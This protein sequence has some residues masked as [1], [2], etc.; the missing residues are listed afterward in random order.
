MRQAGNHDEKRNTDDKLRTIGGEVKEPSVYHGRP[1]EEERLRNKVLHAEK[2]S[3]SGVVVGGLDAAADKEGPLSRTDASHGAAPAGRGGATREAPAP[4]RDTGNWFDRITNDRLSQ[5]G[6]PE[7]RVMPPGADRGHADE[8]SAVIHS[9]RRGQVHSSCLLLLPGS[10]DGNGAALQPSPPWLLP[11]PFPT[12]ES[13]FKPACLSASPPLR[14]RASTSSLQSTHADG[15]ERRNEAPI[16]IDEWRW[17][18]RPFW[19]SSSSVYF[20]QP[21]NRDT[22]TWPREVALRCNEAARRLPAF[23]VSCGESISTRS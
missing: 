14:L 17:W 8:A 16:S 10:E 3:G 5:W 2:H 7:P 1:F 20:S 12:E 19:F 9:W 4:S 6:Q 23:F 22:V 18:W 13:L 11:A 15:A 21:I